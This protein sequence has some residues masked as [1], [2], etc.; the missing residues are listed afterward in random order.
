MFYRWIHFLCKFLL[1][2]VCDACCKLRLASWIRTTGYQLIFF[3]IGQLPVACHLLYFCM[4][5]TAT[6]R[7]VSLQ[8]NQTKLALEYSSDS[9]LL[10]SAPPIIDTWRKAR[11]IQQVR[12]PPKPT[13]PPHHLLHLLASVN[14]Y[15]RGH[16]GSENLT[17]YI[18][19]RHGYMV[20]NAC[21]P[22]HS[23]QGR[24]LCKKRVC[25]HPPAS[26][27]PRPPSRPRPSTR[28]REPAS[29]SQS[30]I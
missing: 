10:L 11:V 13:P 25:L 6:G 2:L 15:R 23:W 20:T 8:Y 22:V 24:G 16:K 18:V 5:R 12:T 27:S 3:A 28:G 17:I 26:L 4:H 1:I 19:S 7:K 9:S 21:P 29:S 30:E 14:R